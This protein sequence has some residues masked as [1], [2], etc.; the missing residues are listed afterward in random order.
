MTVKAISTHEFES[1]FKMGIPMKEV[2]WPPNLEE[3]QGRFFPCACGNTHSFNYIDTPTFLDLGMFKVCVLV[4]ECNYL[5]VIKLKSLFSNEIKNLGS[6][7]FEKNKKRFGFKLEYP[8]F[9]E[10]IKELL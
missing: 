6:C 1:K 4:K 5:N 10:V 9:D 2:P 3:Y 8:K 7:K